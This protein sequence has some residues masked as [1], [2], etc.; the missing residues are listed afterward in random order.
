MKILFLPNFKVYHLHQ[1][2][3]TILDPNKY[4]NKKK[5]WFFKFFQNAEV[6][7]IDNF[8][9]FPFTIIEKIIKFEIFQAI[10]AFLKQKNYDLIISHSYNSGFILSLFRSIFRVSSPPHIVI[11]IG[12][13]NGG[14]EI[15]YQINLI[16]FALKSVDGLIY[17]SRIN[18]EFYSKHF[19]S[20]DRI[21]IPFGIDP[22]YFKPLSDSPR[23]DYAL[24]IGYAKRDF[25]TLID[26]WKSID[27]PLK[28]V[29]VNKRI[30]KREIN[31][32]IEFIPKVPINQLKEFIH[33]SKMVVLP[34]ENEKYS[35]GQ[36]TF[37]QSMAMQ[38]PVIVNL[39]P[40]IVDY[41]DDNCLTY[42]YQNVEDL[43]EKV[44]GLLKNQEIIDNL[45]KKAR[46]SVITTFN[47]KNMVKSIIQYVAEKKSQNENND[48]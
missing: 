31:S 6:E 41:I 12:C 46:Q 10:V 26:A 34:I 4:L 28:I 19:S 42:E 43:M 25:S 8:S 2:D 22:E 44:C 40:G 32:K 15:Q 35:V 47:E 38:K 21:F 37:L 7:I 1:D 13:L 9:P 27:F 39:V 29:G 48:S 45:S 23:N 20:I 5:Y 33:H 3:P 14:N 18:E 11:D 17:H 36:M 30:D 16:R 24:S